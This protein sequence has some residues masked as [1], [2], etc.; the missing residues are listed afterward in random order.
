M[1]VRIGFAAMPTPMNPFRQARVRILL[2]A[3]FFVGYLAVQVGVQFRCLLFNKECNAAWAM[4]AARAEPDLFVQWQAGGETP[5]DE[6]EDQGRV[7]IV[8]LKVDLVRFAP[9]YLCSQ[10]PTAE[11]VRV[12]SPDPKDDKFFPCRR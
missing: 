7:T 11:A 3:V 8:G 2:S 4:Y 1:F 10:L 9:S 6:L 12:S 5:L